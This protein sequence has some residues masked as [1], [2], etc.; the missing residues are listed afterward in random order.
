M[1]NHL[2]IISL[3]LISI[4]GMAQRQFDPQTIELIK[5]KKIASLLMENKSIIIEFIKK[6]IK[7]ENKI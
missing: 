5:T 3:V 6:K 2:I 7:I 4:T 1:K